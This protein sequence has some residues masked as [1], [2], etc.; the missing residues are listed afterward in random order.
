MIVWIYRAMSMVGQAAPQIWE[1]PETPAP[2]A[3]TAMPPRSMNFGDLQKG[4]RAELNGE[5]NDGYYRVLLLVIVLAVVLF[6]LILYWRQ[7]RK[8]G[9]PPESMARLAWQLSVGLHFPIGTRLLL[10]WVG[11]STRVPVAVLL[12]SGEVFKASVA[13][14]SRQPTFGVLREWGVRRLARLERL[15]FEST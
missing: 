7:K 11:R 10:W 6:G 9:G 13:E 12:I 3:V 8:D 4:F 14:W 15:L 1:D 2:K 5:T